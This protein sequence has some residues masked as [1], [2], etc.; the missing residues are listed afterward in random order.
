MTKLRERARTPYGRY[1]GHHPTR[2]P[3]P[4]RTSDHHPTPPSPL[5]TRKPRTR[6][7]YH[8][9]APAGP[10]AAGSSPHTRGL[11]SPTTQC[12]PRPRIIPAHAGFTR[13]AQAGRQR[14]PDHPRTRGVYSARAGTG[15]CASG[16]S[17][18]TRGLRGALTGGLRSPGIIPAHAGFTYRAARRRKARPDHPR[19]RG[20]YWAA[21]ALPPGT[22]GSSPHT[23]GLHGRASPA[24]PVVRI[25]PAHAGFTRRP[26]GDGL[27][28]Q[29]SSP[30]TRGLQATW[31]GWPLSSGIIPAHAGFTRGPG[32]PRCHARDHPRTRGVY[33]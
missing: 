21:R 29:G 33:V 14:P 16:S 19:T 10:H 27:Y 23:R 20:V 18:H 3:D 2:P 12:L 15:P 24:P 17:P 1:R 13:P 31:R 5:G 11:P 4:R 8:A 28:P 6:G 26:G 25:I 32:S 30:H 9:G 7:V 22:V